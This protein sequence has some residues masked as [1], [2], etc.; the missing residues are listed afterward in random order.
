MNLY[1]VNHYSIYVHCKT[2]EHIYVINSSSDVWW[3]YSTDSQAWP[4]D[5]KDTHT[6]THTVSAQRMGNHSK[7]FTDNSSEAG[8]D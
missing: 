1:F 6:C 2:V 7:K 5:S 8:R 4:M 3:I